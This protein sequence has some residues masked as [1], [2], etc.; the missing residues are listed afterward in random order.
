[1]TLQERDALVSQLVL[2][3]GLKRRPYRCT[4][5]KLTVGIGRNLEDRDLSDAAITLLVTEDIDE[6][7]ADLADHFAWFS[8][9]DSI[10]QRALLDLRFNLGPSRFRGFRKMLTAL[11]AGDYG[12]AA[13]QMVDSDWATQVQRSRV[14]RLVAMLRTGQAA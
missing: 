12:E 10:R 8:K 9:L 2:H 14:T 6:C 7:E 13:A 3:E 4:A 11:E 1:M 5:G